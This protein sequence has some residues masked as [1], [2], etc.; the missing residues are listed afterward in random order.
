MLQTVR[1]GASESS[2]SRT[3]RL[4]RVRRDPHERGRPIGHGG[5]AHRRKPAPQPLDARL[6]A[7]LALAR[8][9]TYSRR[10]SSKWRIRT[11]TC[12]RW[13]ARRSASCARAALLTLRSRRAA[14]D[15]AGGVEGDGFGRITRLD[16]SRMHPFCRVEL[17]RF[18]SIVVVACA[19]AAAAAPPPSPTAPEGAQQLALSA[20]DALR[21]RPLSSAVV[22]PLCTRSS[23]RL[24]AP[25]R[26]RACA[27][28][29]LRL[30]QL[31]RP[32]SVRLWCQ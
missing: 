5:R 17:A 28:A 32:P 29:V 15:P 12:R 27:S 25:P 11:R 8:C 7:R 24:F 20:P 22:T 6:R 31:G 4:R 14:G 18:I 1:R 19:A 23:A 21:S 13:W 26:Q 30:R 16:L 2:S 3:I 10:C 9:P